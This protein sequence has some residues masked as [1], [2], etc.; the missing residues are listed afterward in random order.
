M[1]VCRVSIKKMNYSDF[2]ACMK[3]E[4]W[5]YMCSSQN[6]E[7]VQVLILFTSLIFLK[8]VNKYYIKYKNKNNLLNILQILVDVLALFWDYNVFFNVA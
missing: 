3:Y 7:S 2:L 5:S 6:M 1:H 8:A 4:C